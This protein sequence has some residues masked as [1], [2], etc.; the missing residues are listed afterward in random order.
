MQQTW[1]GS[2][3]SYRKG[4]IEIIK[5]KPEHY[6]MS[7]VF[8]VA[9]HAAP[10]EKIV[11]GKNLK[12]VI[13]TLRAEG[14]SPWFTASHDEFCVVMDGE[15]DVHFIKPSDGPL[16]DAQTEGSVRLDGTPSGKSMGFVRLRRGHQALLP[17]GAAYRF[18][19]AGQ[20]V[21]LVQTILGRYSVEKWKDI[22]IQ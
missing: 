16:V 9:S 20:G 2:L 1:L 12:Y 5:G 6:A 14:T 8:E 19:T 4:S 3:D 17:A 22:C 18:E 15:I 21:L 7:N 13:E 10:Y 11:V